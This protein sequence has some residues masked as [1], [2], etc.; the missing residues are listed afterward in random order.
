MLPQDKE[1]EDISMSL[2]SEISTMEL[3]RNKT[4]IPLLC[5]L[6]YGVTANDFGYTYLLLEALPGNV[7]HSRMAF[8]IPD[9]HKGNFAAQLARY[10]YELST[11]RFSQ[12][13]RIIDSPESGVLEL[14]PFAI[15]GSS[16][17]G[18]LS[19][20]LEYFYLF[21][22][23][24]TNAIL[25]DHR[26]EQEWKAAAWLLEKSLSAMITEE[27][28]YGPFPLCPLDLHYNNMLVDGDYNITGI[29]DWSNT[30]TVPIERFAII[31]EFIPPPPASG[32]TN[33]Q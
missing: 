13:G 21:P 27:H 11:I 2:L 10:V 9:R 33:K 12:I 29:I 32:H 31:P 5:V 30:Q 4:T 7:L 28:I 22:R 16:P 26:E 20:S 25:Q 24:Q 19:T 23:G 14:L 18:P 3:I 17:V 15:M 6:G 8:S 1:D